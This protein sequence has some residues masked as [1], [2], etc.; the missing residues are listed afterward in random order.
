MRVLVI[1]ANGML[2]RALVAR[3]A[4]NARYVVR[5]AV[6][7]VTDMLPADVDVVEIGNMTKHPDWSRTLKG[8][9]V[10]IH[11]AARAHVMRDAAINPLLEYRLTNTVA[12]IDLAQRAA[13]AGVQRFLF[14]SSIKV[15]GEETKLG[16]PFTSAALAMPQDAYAISKMEAEQGLQK[17]AERAGMTYVIVRP[18]LVYGPGVKANFEKMMEWVDRGFPVPLA[19]TRNKR[20]FVALENL[21]DLLVRC[22]EHPA[23]ANQTLLVSDGEDLST[24][25][26]LYRLGN[27]MGRPARMFPFPEYLL[28]VSAMILGRSDMAQRLCG[29]LQVD[30]SETCRKLDWRPPVTVDEG[31]KR[32]VA[33]WRSSRPQA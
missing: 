3:L 29:S 23:A 2:G 24:S 1:G 9:D 14:V 15:N 27:A 7:R 4:T 13:E 6:R 8:V 5:A 16:V 10:I 25:E 21:V 17:I 22:I 11:V 33:A 31:L 26:L 12:T 20:S 28:R 30:I 32:T 18:P 19:N